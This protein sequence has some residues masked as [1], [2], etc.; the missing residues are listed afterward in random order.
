MCHSISWISWEWTT[1]PQL[2]K[3]SL[4]RAG[5]GGREKENKSES[6]ITNKFYR[7][8]LSGAITNW[9][10]RFCENIYL[11]LTSTPSGDFSASM[12]DC[13][14]DPLTVIRPKGI[15]AFVSHSNW[16][17]YICDTFWCRTDSSSWFDYCWLSCCRLCL[18]STS[19]RTDTTRC[20]A[21]ASRCTAPKYRTLRC[22]ATPSTI[23][24]G[25]RAGKVSPMT[26]VSRLKSLHRR[27]DCKITN[28]FGKQKVISF[29]FNSTA[30]RVW[31][32]IRRCWM[33][34]DRAQAFPRPPS[35]DKSISRR[36]C[37]ARKKLEW[38][39][40]YLPFPLR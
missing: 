20:R 29:S 19:S 23:A 26:R 15:A 9:N 3:P 4:T 6:Q 36:Y 16:N 7:L 18:C 11:I 34:L 17:Y 40:M 24:D 27:D 33:W 25:E 10:R 38:T 2:R 35:S 31:F 14:Y 5:E 37:F 28:Q 30:S 1:H 8:Y 12:I 22:S 39:K 21:Q 13:F 32:V